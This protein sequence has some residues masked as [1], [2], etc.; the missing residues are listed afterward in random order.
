MQSSSANDRCQQ[1][2]KA[3]KSE[4]PFDETLAFFERAAPPSPQAGAPAW[5]WPGLLRSPLHHQGRRSGSSRSACRSGLLR[6]RRSRPGQ[7]HA[8]GPRS[9]G[10]WGGAKHSKDARGHFGGCLERL[11]HKVSPLPPL[12]PLCGHRRQESCIP[13]SAQVGRFF[14]NA[15][16]RQG[17]GMLMNASTSRPSTAFCLNP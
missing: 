8:G 12:G 13:T 14:A 11:C 1:G 5:I 17:C 6:G 4:D 7:V 9:E 2:S 16:A 3:Q 15:A 10:P